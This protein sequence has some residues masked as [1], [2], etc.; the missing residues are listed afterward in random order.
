M[1]KLSIL[2]GLLVIGV[3][4]AVDC[5]PPIYLSATSWNDVQLGCKFNNYPGC[6]EWFSSTLFFSWV[7]GC[8]KPGT[9]IIK[10]PTGLIFPPFVPIPVS[11]KPT[12]PFCCPYLINKAYFILE[13]YCPSAFGLSNPSYPPTGSDWG[14]KPLCETSYGYGDSQNGYCYSGIGDCPEPSGTVDCTKWHS[15]AIHY[16][17]T[18]DDYTGPDFYYG[19]WTHVFPTAVFSFD[20]IPGQGCQLQACASTIIECEGSERDCDYAEVNIVE[21]FDFP[22]RDQNVTFILDDEAWPRSY[23]RYEDA[24]IGQVNDDGNRFEMPTTATEIFGPDGLIEGESYD[25]TF[26]VDGEDINYC[27]K[28]DCTTN[29][30]WVIEAGDHSCKRVCNNGT[31]C[32]DG[33]CSLI[34]DEGAVNC[35][36]GIECVDGEWDYEQDITYTLVERSEYVENEPQHCSYNVLCDKDVGAYWGDNTVELYA[37]TGNRF[38]KRYC[39]SGT[40]CPPDTEYVESIGSCACPMGKYFDTATESCVSTRIFDEPVKHPAYGLP[41]GITTGDFNDDGNLDLVTG[42]LTKKYVN[43]YAGDGT[44]DLDSPVR[45]LVNGSPKWVESGDFD[46]DGSLDIITVEG[47]PEEISFLGGNGDG[48]FNEPLVTTTLFESRR[49]GFGTG[50]FNED[51]VLD[52]IVSDE[53]SFYYYQGVGNGLFQMTYTGDRGAG[54]SGL[55]GNSLVISEYNNDDH[56][57]VFIIDYSTESVIVFEGDGAGSFNKAATIPTGYTEAIGV[58]DFNGDGYLDLAAHL[59]RDGVL[60][61]FNGYGDG[62]FIEESRT[63]SPRLNGVVSMTV[64]DFTNNGVVDVIVTGWGVNGPA[65]FSGNGDST[66]DYVGGTSTGNIPYLGIKGDFNNDGYLDF[67]QVANSARRIAYLENVVENQV[68]CARDEYYDSELDECLPLDLLM[69]DCIGKGHKY[70]MINGECLTRIDC[71]DCDTFETGSFG[72]CSDESYASRLVN[73]GGWAAQVINCPAPG[74]VK[75]F[76]SYRICYYLPEGLPCSS[77]GCNVKQDYMV[78]Y[79]WRCDPKKGL[80]VDI[81][82]VTHSETTL[83]LLPSIFSYGLQ[84]IA[85]VEEK[86]FEPID[87]CSC[88]AQ[89]RALNEPFCPEYDELTPPINC[90]CYADERLFNNTKW[91]TDYIDYIIYSPEER[92]Q[93][94]D[95][96][97]NCYWNPWEQSFDLSLVDSRPGLSEMENWCSNALRGDYCDFVSSHI[98]QFNFGITSLID[99]LVFSYD[100]THQVP[101]K[102]TSFTRGDEVV[103]DDGLSDGVFLLEE[104]GIVW[105]EFYVESSVSALKSVGLDYASVS[106]FCSADASSELTVKVNG[107]E[108]GVITCSDPAWQSVNFDISRLKQGVNTVTLTS[109]Y[110]DALI[111][112]DVH[113]ESSWGTGITECGVDNTSPVREELST[114]VNNFIVNDDNV[115]VINDEGLYD[116]TN[117]VLL[118][119]GDVEVLDALFNQGLYYVLT[120]DGLLIGDPGDYTLLQFSESYEHLFLLEGQVLIAGDRI[121]EVAGRDYQVSVSEAAYSDQGLFFTNASGL[122]FWE[123]NDFKSVSQSD[124]VFFDDFDWNGDGVVDVVGFDGDSVN[125]W[126]QGPDFFV[127]EELISSDEVLELGV[128]DLYHNGKGELFY[129]DNA[130]PVDNG[131]PYLTRLMPDLSLNTSPITVINGSPWIASSNS[132]YVLEGDSLIEYSSPVASCPGATGSLMNRLKFG[133][134]APVTVPDL[135]FPNINVDPSTI[136]VNGEPFGDLLYCSEAYDFSMN[137]IQDESDSWYDEF[138]FTLRLG[139]SPLYCEGT[140]DIPY[141]EDAPFVNVDFTCQ[142]PNCHWG[143]PVYESFRVCVS[144]GE[145][146]YENCYSLDT[147]QGLIG[148]PDGV[149]GRLTPG[150]ISRGEP[151]TAELWDE[152]GYYEALTGFYLKDGSST[153]CINSSGLPVKGAGEPVLLSD[154]CLVEPGIYDAYVFAGDYFEHFIGS[155]TIE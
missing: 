129:L 38:I 106:V 21:V 10:I 86:E 76:G 4:G 15:A 30:G 138:N 104:G 103:F 93:R 77:T 134:V 17:S 141:P 85:S 54:I 146:E 147:V 108:A 150:T 70:D 148:Y 31:A 142:L 123:G 60:T 33:Q 107:D 96:G 29:R 27:F 72:Y 125:A 120:S 110:S 13:Y 95:F 101:V 79:G 45:S 24:I 63:P 2:I 99:M 92:C 144:A 153:Y 40:A 42:S 9:I 84:D 47:Y 152:D 154:D 16:L 124:V 39:G 28:A 8:I 119:I 100:E 89:E 115:F 112:V 3:V 132:L 90:S 102:V 143:L 25:L 11:I 149:D 69:V 140:S 59:Y 34:T 117:E 41:H 7:G 74:T 46:N 75:D 111:G 18:H 64:E 97:D 26:N 137:F 98:Y 49:D 35:N 57:D 14:N 155:L 71:V 20:S 19:L 36:Y 22:A 65:F 1:R 91:T 12:L 136:K 58:G 48:S 43:Y 44:G 55:T 128:L 5:Q 109:V 126:L 61:V 118:D 68:F 66:F 32:S 135:L 116:L 94:L 127:E 145:F 73:N 51:G 83:E 151:V 78:G 50:D 56:L 105:Q 130:S 139:D 82:T 122:F 80:V 121:R 53:T 62:T 67:I 87:S 81:P 23:V 113:S 133:E 114:G 37:K 6:Q 52:V 131:T 88:A